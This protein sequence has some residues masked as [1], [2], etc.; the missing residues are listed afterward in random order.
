MMDVLDAAYH[1]AHAHQ[2]GVAALAPRMGKSASTLAHE[3]TQ[4][5]S[6]KFGLRD[7]VMLSH[8]CGSTAIVQAFAAAM[9]GPFIPC[10]SADLRDCDMQR[11]GDTVREFGDVVAGF[12]AAMADGRVT[13]NELRRLEREALEAIA[14]I[15]A[16]LARAR[17]VHESARPRDGGSGERGGAAD[18]AS[19]GGVAVLRARRAGAA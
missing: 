7:A 6:A 8:L 11:V 4:Q 5:G 17:Q 15:T 18:A 2:G 14:Q 1:A 3:L 10:A 19:V 16:L 9:G 13:G 12:S